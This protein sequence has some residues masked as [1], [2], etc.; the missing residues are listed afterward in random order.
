MPAATTMSATSA[1]S[2]STSSGE[3]WYQITLGGS[4][5]GQDAALGTVIGPSVAKN[6][7]AE[8]LD[9]LIRVYLEQ[10]V[11][12]E[13]FVDTF[14]RIGVAPFKARVYAPADQAA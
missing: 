3:E 6:D 10:R 7:V 13:R 2:A 11:E 12:S 1:S 14:R 4:A 9:R 8:T 5:G